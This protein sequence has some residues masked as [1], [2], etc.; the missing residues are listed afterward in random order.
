MRYRVLG[1]V[2]VARGDT[3]ISILRRRER[4]LLG[5]LLLDVGRFVPVDRLVD[6]LWDGEPPKHARRAVQSHV[7][8][9]RAPVGAGPGEELVRGGGG[10]MLRV[11]PATVDAHRFRALV[12]EARA[13]ADL[14]HRMSLLEHALDLWRGEVMQDAATARLRERIGH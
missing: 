11:D 13:A 12:A 8:R 5:V 9:I 1:P 6:L 4:C 3:V 7:A 10:Y 14:S 2:E